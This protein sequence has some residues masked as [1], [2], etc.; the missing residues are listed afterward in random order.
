VS[1]APVTDRFFTVAYVYNPSDLAIL[2]SRLG[3]EGIYTYCAGLGHA[4]VEPGLTTAL[5]GVRVRVHEGDLADAQA[6]LATL[7]PALHRAS[8]P[9]GFWP[10]D[11]LLFLAIAFF[12]A[13]P[14]P[15]QLPAYVL[16]AA[17]AR[18]EA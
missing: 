6:I 2:L 10:L 3:Y 8:L 9:F 12:G 18:R 16:G 1:E 17:T 4:S 5:G 14:P 15:R 11:L 13:A 7:D